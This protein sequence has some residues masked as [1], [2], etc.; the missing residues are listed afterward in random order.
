MAY[1]KLLTV[2]KVLIKLF[3]REENAVGGVLQF[4]PLIFAVAN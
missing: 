1:F 4:H 2:P 3:D